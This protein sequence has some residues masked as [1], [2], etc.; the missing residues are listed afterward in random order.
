MF[1]GRQDTVRCSSVSAVG[2]FSWIIVGLVAGLIAR[3]IVK[4]D[5]SGCIYT[6]VVGVLGALLGG[7]LM[8]ATGRKGVVEFEFRSVLVAAVGA[9]LLLMILQALGGRST[10]PRSRRR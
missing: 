4:D 10:R 6:V 9:V 5:R 8:N 3:W 2:L 7:A 1:A